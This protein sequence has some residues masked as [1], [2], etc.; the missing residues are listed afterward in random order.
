MLLLLRALTSETKVLMDDLSAR[1]AITAVPEQSLHTIIVL[2]HQLLCKFEPDNR[3]NFETSDDIPAVG[4]ANC[5]FASVIKLA[6]AP[7]SAAN[8][9]KVSCMAN[10]WS[11]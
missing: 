4:A 7:A 9:K 1:G 10:S 11:Y 6:K 5:L 3:I 2:K 8:I